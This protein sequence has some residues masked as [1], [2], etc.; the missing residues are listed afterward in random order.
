VSRPRIKTVTAREI[1]DSRGFPTLEAEVRLDDGTM[2]RAAV[3]SGASTGEHEAVELRDGDPGRFQGKGVRKAVRHVRERLS[4]AI[5]GMDP[6]D[7]EVIDQTLIAT[8]GSPN[9]STLGANALLGVSMAVSRAAAGKEPLYRYLRRC[10]GLPGEACLLP[11]PMLNIINGGKHADSGLDIQ[12]FMIVPVGA[13]SFPDALRMGAEIY[14]VLKKLLAARKLSTAVGDEGGFAPRLKSHEEALKIIAEA[15]DQAG[16]AGHVELALDAAASEFFLDGT[17]RFQGDA[18]S[19]QELTQRYS[20]WVERY[21]ILSIED[22]LAEDDWSGWKSLTASLGAKTRVIGDDLFVTNLK[23]LERGI[24]EASANA[25]LIKLN[26][27]G[28]VTETV[29][30]VLRAQEAGFTTVISHRS[31]ETEDPY[32]ADFSVALGA[33]AIKTGAPCRS[34]RLAKYNQL[35]RIH[36]ELGARSRF[37]GANVFRRDT[38]VSAKG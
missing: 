2:G 31:G 20:D 24:R 19:A 18:L 8:D 30:A 38:A 27:I 33:G 21:G 16:Y 22:P 15:I 10:F 11:A 25:I 32:I 28:T 9:K 23:R 1:L 13:R 3:P 35:L 17:Y 37:A 34:E 14:Q 26:Q 7:Q 4:A 6:S 5:C 12:E 36:D 29:R